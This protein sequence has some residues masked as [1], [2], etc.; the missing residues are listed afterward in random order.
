MRY[1]VIPMWALPVL[2][3]SG[4]SSFEITSEPSA[5]VYEDGER[6]A[7]TPYR[8]KL[9]SG[10][11]NL[12]LRRYGYVEEDLVVSSLAPKHMHVAMQWV[13]RTRIDTL[14]RGAKVLDAETKDELG[15]APCSLFLARPRRILVKLDGF[16]PV[17]RDLVPNESHVFELKSLSGYQSA[18]Y[19]RITFQ[20]AQGPVAIFDR[21]AGE[22]IGTTPVTLNLEA[23]SALEYRLE[24]FHPQQVL[25]S[26]TAPHRIDIVLEPLSKVTI[27]GPAGA[28]VYR[29]GGLERIGELPY[30]VEVEGDALFEIKK[31][32]FKD[33]SIAVSPGSP[34]TLRVELEPIPYKTIVTDPPGA[35]VYRLGGL[36]KLGDAPFTTVVE[37]ER[38]FEIK[39]KGFKP[40]IIGM[41]PG[42]PKQIDIPLTPLPRDDP[43][44]AAIGTLDSPV[45]DT[46]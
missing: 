32:G 24:G 43:D 28:K 20:S 17:E 35:E 11:R 42:S 34:R 22:Q 10:A 15:T 36:E 19:R 3:L 7:S 26:R 30:S 45:V 13:G 29:A 33:R 1:R 4:C 38:V 8:F 25:V 18:F 12:T 31:E 44:A 6:I 9:M 2:L 27:D 14:P 5:E 21:V 39:K 16:E 41:G 37:A 40:A 23:G 46:F